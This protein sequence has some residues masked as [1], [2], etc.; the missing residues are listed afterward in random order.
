MLRAARRFPTSSGEMHF[1]TQTA[2]RL[3]C[4]RPL[5]T[6]PESSD[7]E[8]PKRALGQFW[9]WTTKERPHWRESP[10]EA[11]VAIA[12][13][14]VTGTTSVTLVRP[15]LKSAGLEGSMTEG[16]WSYRILSVLA[17]SPIYATML[18]TFGTLAGRH[19]FFATMGKKIWGR[20]VPRSWT[21]RITVAFCRTTGRATGR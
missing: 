15:T 18:I 9:R 8:P 13:F 7:P 16:P 5:C 20:F 2:V 3:L 21:D 12:V 17:I 11:V 14:G 6:R 19:R 1:R 10:S 4:R